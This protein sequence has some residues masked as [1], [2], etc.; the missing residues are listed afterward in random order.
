MKFPHFK[1]RKLITALCVLSLAQLVQLLPTRA[2]DAP[3]AD[4]E[5][6]AGRLR[7][8]VEAVEALERKVAL[9]ESG[10]AIAREERDQ[11]VAELEQMKQAKVDAVAADLFAEGVEH[12]KILEDFP[13]NGGIAATDEKGVFR[14]RMGDPLSGIRY[15]GPLDLPVTNYEISLEARRTK[16][17]DFFCA[18]TFPVNDIKTC[19]TF[20]AGGWGGALAGISS[21][22]GM[23]AA[24][25]DTSTFHKFELNQWYAFRIQVTPE[26]LKVWMDGKSIVDVELADRRVGMRWGDIEYCVPFGLATYVTAGEFRNFK[27]GRTDGKPIE[28]KKPDAAPAPAPADAKDGEGVKDGDAAQ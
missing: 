5:T 3:S 6:V 23:D 21:L 8:T 16:G 9:L 15:T 10:A 17:T 11:A 26:S 1:N 4:V 18:L 22:D 19:C 14:M 7:A 27:I 20:V 28:P 25:N 2:Q 12:W 24:N 13:S